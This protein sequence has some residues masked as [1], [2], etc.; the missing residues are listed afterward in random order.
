MSGCTSASH[1]STRASRALRELTFQVAMRTAATVAAE[2]ASTVGLRD[3]PRPTLE[4]VEAVCWSDYLC[5]WCYVAQHRDDL[6]RRLGVEVVHLPYELHPEI[7]PEGRR[8]RPD[9][10]LQHTFDRIAVECEAAGLPFRPPTRMPNTRRALETAEL[11]RQRH[12]DA[13]AAVHRGCFAAQFAT[14]HP[15]D[16][17]D[18]LD[19]I[20]D[21][22]G[23]PVAEVRTAVDA[24]AGREL[25]EASMARAR[26]AGV[27]STPTWVIGDGFVVPGALDPATMERWVTKLVARHG[28]AAGAVPGSGPQTAG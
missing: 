7:G 16:D 12:P 23:A 13:F 18:V 28:R 22:A 19:E 1:S 15:L 10:R 4:R 2:P 14:G 8:V 27:T 17:A 20:V 3:Q 11:V 6:L 21:R 24:G 5:P 9:G 25:V 26:A